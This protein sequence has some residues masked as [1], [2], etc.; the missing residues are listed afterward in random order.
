MSSLHQGF[1][2]TGQSGDTEAT[3][4]WLDRMDGNLT[5]AAEAEAFFSVVLGIHSRRTQAVATGRRDNPQPKTGMT[6]RPGGTAS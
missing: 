4:R 3:F 5:Q 6:Q 1:Q 2:Q